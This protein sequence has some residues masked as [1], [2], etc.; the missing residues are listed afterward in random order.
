MKG[1]IELDK[2]NYETHT[3]DKVSLPNLNYKLYSKD[4]NEVI[5]CPHCGKELKYGEGYTS[6]EFHNNFGFGYAVCKDCY[7]T[8]FAIRWLFE[9]E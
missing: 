5:N 4:M 2:W 3:Y 7:D 1:N 6:L 9:N 8:E